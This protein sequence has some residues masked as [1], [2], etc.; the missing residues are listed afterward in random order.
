M[1]T[2]RL[3][4]ALSWIEVNFE[5]HSMQSISKELEPGSADCLWDSF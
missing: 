2:L 3:V 5:P 1:E 4:V